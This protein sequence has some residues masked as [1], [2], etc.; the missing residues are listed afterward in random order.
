MGGR[1]GNVPYLHPKVIQ[2]HRGK[3]DKTMKEFGKG[4]LRSG[5]KT[6]PV[7]T[8]RRQAIAIAMNVA[9]RAAEK[10]RKR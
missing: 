7:V 5:S 8:N 6:G 3:V 9:R 10:G 2:K 4:T 1:H